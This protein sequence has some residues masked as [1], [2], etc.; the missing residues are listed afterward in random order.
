MSSTAR[1]TFVPWPT[2]VYFV[3]WDIDTHA[4]YTYA[5]EKV[6]FDVDC[7]HWIRDAIE[8][9]FV[10]LPDLTQFRKRTHISIVL[11]S[12]WRMLEYGGNFYEG[13]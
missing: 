1:A 10:A 8:S 4:I 7:P 12:E 5:K 2:E 3:L 11:L 9:Q 13:A 6:A